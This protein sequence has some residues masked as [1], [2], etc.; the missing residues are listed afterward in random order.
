MN[1]ICVLRDPVCIAE[2]Y[3][4]QAGQEAQR[5]FWPSNGK[6]VHCF[7]RWYEY[8]SF[9]E[10]WGTAS[11]RTLETVLWPWILV[12]IWNTAENFLLMYLLLVFYSLEFYFQTFLKWFVNVNVNLVYVKI[13]YLKLKQLVFYSLRT[14]YFRKFMIKLILSV[15]ECSSAD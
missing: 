10:V 13:H 3:H 9:G 11:Y 5:S 8:A 2:H 7:C 4:G 6:K 14:S 1:V 15:L 12:I